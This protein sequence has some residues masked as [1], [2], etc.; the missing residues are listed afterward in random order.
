MT[1]KFHE[2]AKVTLL[3]TLMAIALLSLT[4]I[5]YANTSTA[6]GQQWTVGTRVYNGHGD[7][8]FHTDHAT[9]AE[10]IAAEFN[11]RSSTSGFTDYL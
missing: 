10:G 2:N 6:P 8:V 7:L 4:G 9:S 3:T 11:I 1:K 5:A